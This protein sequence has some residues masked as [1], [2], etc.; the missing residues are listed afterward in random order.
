M[1]SSVIL[2]R[3]IFPS[4]DIRYT[5]TGAKPKMRREVKMAPEFLKPKVPMPGTALP[6]ILKG[7]HVKEGGEA[8]EEEQDNVVPAGRVALCSC[9][10]NPCSCGGFVC[11]AAG[12]DFVCPHEVS[13]NENQERVVENPE[14]SVVAYTPPNNR[15]NLYIITNVQCFVGG[16]QCV[17]CRGECCPLVNRVVDALMEDGDINPDGVFLMSFSI[18]P[19]IHSY[20]R[21]QGMVLW[22]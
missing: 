6:V 7:D 10:G 3:S 17:L 2:D 18:M 4:Q 20:S 15:G 8:M 12:D 11:K 1:G 14:R 19:F 5:G 21:I 16:R 13:A 22:P 9:E